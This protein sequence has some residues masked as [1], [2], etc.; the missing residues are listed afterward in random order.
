M[1]ANTNTIKA[2]QGL[3][4]VTQD[5]LW[6]PKTQAAL[7]ALIKPPSGATDEDPHFVGDGMWPWINAKIDGEDILITG[8]V[9]TAFG[10]DSDKMDSGETA[11]GFSTKDNPSFLGCALP[12]RRDSNPQLR[13]SPIPKLPWKTIVEFSDPVT[14]KTVVTKLIDEG[15]AKWT[16]HGGDMSVAAAKEFDPNA[17]S[18]NFEKVLNIRIVGGAKYVTA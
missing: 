15:P 14:G 18:N 6:G 10:G 16:K 8:A 2:I 11:S 7:D 1:N 12:M 5:G 4:G 9:V 17:T 3:L 13:G